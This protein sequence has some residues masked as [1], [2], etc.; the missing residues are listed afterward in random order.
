MLNSDAAFMA[1]AASATWAAS[2]AA[3]LAAHGRPFSLTLTLPPLAIVMFKARAAHEGGAQTRQALVEGAG[4]RHAR[5]DREREPIVDAGRF[6]IKRIVGDT[7]TV[8]ADCFADGHE[9]SCACCSTATRTRANWTEAP[10]TSLGNDRWRGAFSV[11]R[12]GTWHYG[13]MAWIDPLL[14]WRHEFVRRE[15]FR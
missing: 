9:V 10:M 15:R 4:H 7:I 5:R 14:T 2:Q 11:D 12:L 13:I 1:A 3:P 8:E 6:P